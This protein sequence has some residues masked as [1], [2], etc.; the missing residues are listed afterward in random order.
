MNS[1]IRN[2]KLFMKFNEFQAI[3]FSRKI[4]CCD[5]SK[6]KPVFFCLLKFMTLSQLSVTLFSVSCLPV[7]LDFFRAVC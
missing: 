7:G 5:C 1:K 3:F 2:H 4:V 6:N